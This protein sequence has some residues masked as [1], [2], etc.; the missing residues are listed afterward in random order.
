MIKERNY[1]ID[2][3]RLVLMFMVCMLHALAHGGVLSSSV[4]G[5]VG[6]DIYWFL[7][8]VCFCSVDGFALI[9]GY[10]A[11]NKEKKYEKLVEMWF[12]IFFYSFIVTI[13][14]T[15]LGLNA[16]LSTKAIIK[17]AF[18]ITFST[19][20]YFTAF[21]ILFL[22]IPIPNKHLFSIDEKTCKKTF[23]IMFILFSIIGVLKDPFKTSMGY[24]PIWL[25][26]LYCMGVLAKRIN[27][28]EK[29]KS[30]TLVMLFL[31][32]NIITLSLLIFLNNNR[33]IN[34]ISPTVLL[35]GIILVVLFSRF[36]LKGTIISKIAPLAFG[37]YLLQLNPVIWNDIINNC[38]S[39]VPNKPI[40]LGLLITFGFCAVLFLGGLIVEFIRSKLSKLIKIPELSKKIVELI[41]KILEKFFVFLK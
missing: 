28:F 38:L 5:T 15:I 29:R 9:S 39:F 27:L 22:A 1:G 17:T 16:S 26:I 12:Q 6:Y 24:S 41:N 23:I 8:I 31:L 19:Y 7:R 33:L 32:C 40:Y 3:L 11:V 34:Y 18:P 25:M 36:K 13:I 10:M 30:I 14:L 21:F 4:S 2:L 37:I 20:W 35:S